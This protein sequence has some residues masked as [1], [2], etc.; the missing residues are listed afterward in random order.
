M[1]CSDYELLTV[2]VAFEW[3]LLN[4]VYRSSLSMHAKPVSASV[5]VLNANATG[6]SF[7]SNVTL[8]KLMLASLSQLLG[9]EPVANET[10][11][12]VLWD[13]TFQVLK[14]LLVVSFQY[15]TLVLIQE[16]SELGCFFCQVLDEM[17]QVGHKPKDL[18]Q[19]ISGWRSWHKSNVVYLI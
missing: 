15:K 1:N 18:F 10:W 16:F 9:V 13:G 3:N 5:W 12:R 6:L 2:E 19:F 8:K 11:S 7:W 4:P 17:Q 14:I